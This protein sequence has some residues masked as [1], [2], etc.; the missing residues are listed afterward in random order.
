METEVHTQ[1]TDRLLLLK[2]LILDR[3]V[4][5]VNIYLPNEQQAVTLD[6]ILGE[7]TT[8]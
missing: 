8:Y 3:M 5:L 4:M 2:G 1:K 7:I 6:N